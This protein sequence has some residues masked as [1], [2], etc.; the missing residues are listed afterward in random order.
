MCKGGVFPINNK[1]NDDEKNNQV[2]NIITKIDEN[3]KRLGGKSFH[4]MVMTYLEMYLKNA[5]HSQMKGTVHGLSYR[6][7]RDE[8]ETSPADAESKPWRQRKFKCPDQRDRLRRQIADEKKEKK[9]AFF[10]QF[11][12]YIR[13][14]CRQLHMSCL[15]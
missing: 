4:H 15:R 1:G 5:R 11:L 14:S 13:S 2:Q 3:L 6:T 12:A 8:T 9:D 7:Y 10:Q